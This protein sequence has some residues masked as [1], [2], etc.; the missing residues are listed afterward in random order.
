MVTS[1]IIGCRTRICSKMV[2]KRTKQTG[3]GPRI[4]LVRCSFETIDAIVKCL[5]EQLSNTLAATT[6]DRNC[7]TACWMDQTP[8][9]NCSFFMQLLTRIFV[10]EVT[11]SVTNWDDL[12]WTCTRSNLKYQILPAAITQRIH[13]WRCFLWES[14]WVPLTSSQD[15]T[16]K[17]LLRKHWQRAP[18]R[19][20]YWNTICSWS[21]F[22]L[23]SRAAN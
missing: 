5:L 13:L 18:G 12:H 7:D 20:R 1:L 2:S 17:K 21:H 10:G 8:C 15:V 6:F 11:A 14:L 23:Y 9:D 22:H 4:L 19:I 3:I 16:I